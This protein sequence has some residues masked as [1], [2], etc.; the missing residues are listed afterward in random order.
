[1]RSATLSLPMNPKRPPGSLK[2]RWWLLLLA[3]AVGGAF[4]VVDNIFGLRQFNFESS[5]PTA[6]KVA[7]ECA[8][9]WLIV[10]MMAHARIRRSSAFVLLIVLIVALT[11]IPQLLNPPASTHAMVGLLY[12][13]AS[14]ATLLTLC[15]LYTPEH[16]KDFAHHFV[17]P[18]IAITFAT[19]LLEVWLSPVSLYGE[20]NLWGLDRRAGIAVVPTTAGLLGVV[21]CAV[22]RG[23]PLLMSVAVVG[24]AASTIS[25]VCLVLVWLARLRRP[26]YILVALPVLV[27]VATFAILSREGLEFTTETRLEIMF[28]TA[29]Q[30]SWFG[31]SPIGAL[32]T[33]KSVAL[34]P[35]DSYIADSLYLEVMHVFGVVPGVAFLVALFTAIYRRFGGVALGVFSLAGVG[36]L[37]LEAWVV[38]VALLFGLQRIW[39]P[40]LSAKNAK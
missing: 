9:A 35:F 7:K 3:F 34:D 30:M 21:G 24:L 12:L 15:A 26:V 16:S 6:V 22:L 31:P 19:Q 11:F 13:V 10:S 23:L 29:A 20:T 4:E 32:A 39:S 27:G 25:L 1:M 36:Y 37:V 8:I 14:A 33:A 38:W 5:A 28:E 17:L 2:S 40:A 18:A